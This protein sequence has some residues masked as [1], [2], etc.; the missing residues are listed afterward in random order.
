[1]R[2]RSAHRLS[3]SCSSSSRSGWRASAP[4]TTDAS[5]TSPRLQEIARARR[6]IHGLDTGS[7]VR[8]STFGRQFRLSAGRRSSHC[9]QRR[10]SA[11]TSPVR[12]SPHRARSAR[13]WTSQKIAA[14]HPSA[15]KVHPGLIMNIA[16]VQPANPASDSHGRTRKV[17]RQEGFPISSSSAAERFRSA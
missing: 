10:T 14:S 4:G 6:R 1:M 13:R 2:K 8:A 16:P 17:G 3:A 12:M 9:T 7:G 5:V 11:I 15:M